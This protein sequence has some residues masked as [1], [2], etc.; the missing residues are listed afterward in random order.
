MIIITLFGLH[1]KNDARFS[2]V[3]RSAK[4]TTSVHRFV[5][6]FMVQIRVSCLERYGKRSS[7]ETNSKNHR[8]V[9]KIDFLLLNF[10]NVQHSRDTK[11]IVRNTRE[12]YIHFVFSHC[13]HSER[14]SIGEILPIVQHACFS[15]THVHVRNHSFSTQAPPSHIDI[16]MEIVGHGF[17]F[18][19]FPV[20][21]HTVSNNS[22]SRLKAVEDGV[23][24]SV[25]HK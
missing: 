12:N 13:R 20:K 2:L 8:V 18:K 21:I 7:N 17:L 22:L 4:T 15:D 6:V 5:A 19:V 16:L 1:A 11:G 25:D 24:F 23:R 14:V 3:F 9:D 10:E